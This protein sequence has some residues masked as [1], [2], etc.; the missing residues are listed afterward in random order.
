MQF[1]IFKMLIGFS[2][3]LS[4]CIVAVLCALGYALKEAWKESANFGN[5]TKE[6]V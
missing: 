4:V 2:I 1:G 6:T 3:F 5:I